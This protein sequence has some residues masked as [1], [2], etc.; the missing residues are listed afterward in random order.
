MNFPEKQEFLTQAGQE[1][2]EWYDRFQ[3]VPSISLDQL[4]PR[5]SCLIVVDVINGFVK[6]G[7]LSD[8]S[9]SE[10][11]PP[12]RD[13]M[14]AFQSRSM[15][16]AAFQDCHAPDAAE[17]SVFPPHCV[18]GTDET[19]LVSELDGISCVRLPKNS[20]NGFLERNFQELLTRNPQMNTFL[21][22]GDC[23]DICVL[24]FCLTLTAALNVSNKK[25]SVIVPVNAVDTFGAPGHNKHV[26]NLAALQLMASAGVQ[27]VSEVRLD[28]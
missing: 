21:V 7:P 9:I 20:T 15:P 1:M 19:E 2:A 13:L 4:D 12:I 14:Q 22:V 5:R 11:I 16:V 26:M 23:T 27:I 8:P 24:Q 18:R 28:G 10:I 17:F 6:F 3:R 25:A